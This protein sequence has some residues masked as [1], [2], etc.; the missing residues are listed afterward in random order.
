MMSSGSSGGP[1]PSGK[2][3]LEEVVERLLF[4]DESNV[5]D[6]KVDQ[7]PFG[8]ATDE[9]RGELLKD[10]FAMANSWGRAEFR[11]ILIGV[12]EVVGGRAEVVG[13]QQHLPEHALQQ[14]VNSRANRPVELS[15]HALDYEGKSIGVLA[16]AKQQRPI[17]LQKSYGRLQANTV[18]V[19]RGSSTVIAAPD[20][21]AQM[22]LAAA[23][24]EPR[25]SCDLLIELATSDSREPIQDTFVA[26]AQI[27]KFSDVDRLPDY[28]GHLPGRTLHDGPDAADRGDHCG[29]AGSFHAH[30]DRTGQVPTET[31]LGGETMYAVVPGG[32]DSRLDHGIRSPHGCRLRTWKR[33]HPR[34]VQRLTRVG[35]AALRSLCGSA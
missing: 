21:I 27:L 7:Y 5:L 9:Q 15:Y 8:G 16:I 20:E 17:Y 24:V 31:H 19:R 23:Q 34:P 13:V 22:G 18:Y 26:S 14:L 1:A 32:S 3:P 2:H 12:R 33:A 4:E 29:C 28:T 11:Y 25:R 35:E 30:G 6:F 10:I